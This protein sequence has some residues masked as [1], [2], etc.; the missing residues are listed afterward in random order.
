MMIKK[1]MILAVLIA[2]ATT[3]SA[4][5]FAYIDSQYILEQ[6]PAYREAQKELNEFS[7]RWRE[8]VEAKKDNLEEMRR[9]YQAEK[10]LLTDDMR[11]QREKEI[12]EKKDELLEYQKDKFGKDGDLFTKRKELIQPL[13]DE[14]FNSLEEMAK[15]RSYA[16]V[17]DKG[18]STNILY[19]DPRYDKSDVVLRKLGLSTGDE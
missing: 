10:I 19:S 2:F 16:I 8:T 1:G 11:E 14:I 12:K 4:Q 18:K 5:R 3:L 6:M 15:E 9:A 7:K 13:Q 17:F